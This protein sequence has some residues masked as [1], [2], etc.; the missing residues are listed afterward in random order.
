MKSGWIIFVIGFVI[1]AAVGVSSDVNDGDDCECDFC[2]C[3][4]CKKKSNIWSRD[5][6]SSI[7]QH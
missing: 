7:C 4:L 5:D 2:Y 3:N 6:N 1:V